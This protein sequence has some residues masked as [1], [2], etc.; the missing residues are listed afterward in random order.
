MQITKPLTPYQIFLSER[1]VGISESNIQSVCRADFITIKH[2]DEIKKFSKYLNF[3]REKDYY[4]HSD[5]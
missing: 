5:P 2:S 3:K 1:K 4:N